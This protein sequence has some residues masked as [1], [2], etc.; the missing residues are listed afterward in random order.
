MKHSKCS[1]LVEMIVKVIAYLLDEILSR[2]KQ[3]Q[4]G[5]IWNNKNKSKKC[6]IEQKSIYCMIPFIKVYKQMELLLGMRSH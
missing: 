2:N 3:E 4:T 5:S 6:Q 1:S